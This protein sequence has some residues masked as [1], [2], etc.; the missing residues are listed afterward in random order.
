MIIGTA[1]GMTLGL[2]IVLGLERFSAWRAA[3]L[4]IA[5]SGVVVV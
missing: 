2:A 5:F 4:G 1:P 3:G